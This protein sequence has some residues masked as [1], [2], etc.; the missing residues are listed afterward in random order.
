MGGPSAEH[1]VSLRSG[2]GVAEALVRRGVRVRPV[3]IPRALTAAQAQAFVAAALAAPPT[4][5]VFIALHGT[6][7]EDGAVQRICEDLHLAYTGSDAAASRLGMDKVASRERFVRAGLQVPRSRTVTAQTQEAFEAGDLAYPLMVKPAD[8]GSSIGI[9]RVEEPGRLPSALREAARYSQVLLVE[10]FIEGRELT[11]GVV[12]DSTLPVVE[13]CPKQGFFDFAAKYTPGMTEYHV[14]A[15]LL[16][17]VAQAVQAA[18]RRAHEAL[19]CRHLSRADLILDA[20]RG[21]VVLEV[22]TIPGFTPTSLLPKAAACIGLT[23]DELC[24]RLVLLAGREA[25]QLARVHG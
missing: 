10:E 6:F 9:S 8:Q 7:G 22:N 18:G 5:V 20:H 4:D 1:E 21:P 24:E 3:V 14:P 15:A 17:A 13:I 11:V 25:A 19:G 2:Q 12:G 16:P 23:Y